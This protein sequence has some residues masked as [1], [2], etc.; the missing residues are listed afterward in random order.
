MT[1]LNYDHYS[2]G[3]VVGTIEDPEAEEIFDD[4]S[5]YETFSHMCDDLSQWSPVVE[6]GLY[7]PFLAVIRCEAREKGI[8]GNDAEL[9]QK[10][11]PWPESQTTGDCVSHFVRAACDVARS[12]DLEYEGDHERWDTRTATE[13]I[14]GHRGHRGAGANCSRLV[15]FVRSSGGMLLRKPYDI[16]GYGRLDLSKYNASVGIKWGGSGVPGSVVAECKKHQI[17]DSVRVRTKEDVL[18][19]YRQG[20]SVGGCSSLGLSRVRNEDGVSSVSGS[21]AHAMH[22]HGLDER[23]ETIGKYGCPLILIQNSWGAWNSGP[24]K[25]LNTDILIP[26]GSCWFPLDRYI[27]YYSNSCF[28]LTEANGWKAR[29]PITIGHSAFG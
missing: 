25:I 24:R 19:A 2:S 18:Q 17:I 1:D 11:N 27:K 22:S 12:I 14:Y 7:L 3:R 9:S 13:P 23:E 10:V 21:W 20:H 16:D 28:A 26:K 15:D 8:T 5:R 29:K 4:R 6:E